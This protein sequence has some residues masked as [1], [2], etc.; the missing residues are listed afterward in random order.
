MIKNVEDSGVT[1]IKIGENVILCKQEIFKNEK[2]Q[3]GE[4]GFLIN[5]R[6][7]IVQ[8]INKIPSD[9][10]YEFILRS[11]GAIDINAVVKKCVNGT[12]IIN[13]WMFC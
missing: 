4:V 2:L 8:F 3:E 6:K 12:H 7:A 9:K 1:P 10:M 13:P 11:N 5:G